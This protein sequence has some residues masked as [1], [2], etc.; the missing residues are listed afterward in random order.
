MSVASSHH[1]TLGPF[2]PFHKFLYGHKFGNLS[3]LALLS[4]V[5]SHPAKGPK[6]KCRKL[7]V[8]NSG[9]ATSSAG[10]YPNTNRC[11]AQWLAQA[12]V[13]SHV[14]TDP[15]CVRRS[16]LADDN[17][18]PSRIAIQLIDFRL[19]GPRGR[20]SRID[21][22]GLKTGESTIKQKASEERLLYSLPSLCRPLHPLEWTTILRSLTDIYVVCSTN[23]GS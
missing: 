11:P 15:S 2:H 12:M 20:R 5:I 6:A 21:S 13:G 9:V 10:N 22:L 14:N 19:L 17:T 23:E 16:S 7:F 4:Q 3:K 1:L 18:A 8:I